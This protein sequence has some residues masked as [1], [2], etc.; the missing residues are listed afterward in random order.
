[1]N[2]RLALAFSAGM[3]AVINPCGFAMLPAYLSYFVGIDDA[4]GRSRGSSVW[5]AIK[6]SLAV[7]VGFMAVFGLMGFVTEI[8]SLQIESKL[9][10]VTMAFGVGLVVLGIA[11]LR[12]FQ[13]TVPLPHL[14][15]GG[16]T[17]Q[18][19]SMVVFGVSYAVASLS[20]TLP[21]FLLYVVLAFT[22]DGPAQGL[23]LFFAYSAGMTVLLT[24]LTV[25]LALARDG[26]VQD[27][28]RLLPKITRIAGGLLVVAGIYLTYWGWYEDQVL[29]RD[30]LDP[31]GPASVLQSLNGDITTWITRVGPG[32]IG[33]VLAA[34]VAAALI[35]SRRR[36]RRGG[37]AAPEGGSLP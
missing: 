19:A 36:R 4:D 27:L 2:G 15:R 11:M 6:V 1:V 12:G 13:P 8:F 31:G 14:E 10:L 29:N 21:V 9:P 18:L 33:L 24:A 5:R 20:C 7:A 30:N 35:V 3:L 22:S 26:L 37:T 25:S 34:F 28:R 32:Q 23:L 17:R 16:D